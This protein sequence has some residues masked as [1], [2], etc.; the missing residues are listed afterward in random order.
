V[1][2]H[3][4]G[5]HLGLGVI[6]GQAC[7]ALQQHR[8]GRAG[9]EAQGPV[10]RVQAGLAVLVAQVQP[11]PERDHPE[12][13]HHAGRGALVAAVGLLVVTQTW[14]GLVLVGGLGA[15]EGLFQQAAA[16]FVEGRLEF[17]LEGEGGRGRRRR[18]L[19]LAPEF[20]DARAQWREDVAGTAV[21]CRRHDC[22][23]RL[24]HEVA[25]PG[26]DARYT[27]SQERHLALARP[28]VQPHA[29]DG[30]HVSLGNR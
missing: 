22:R 13:G 14:G 29:Q 1:L 4:P 2:T 11:R 3:K 24:C 30:N 5:T 20:L 21:A 26:W 6:D 15:V 25:F 8:R 27:S 19:E 23:R 16:R 28:Q 10:Q 18:G 12:R 9:A 7:H 17:L